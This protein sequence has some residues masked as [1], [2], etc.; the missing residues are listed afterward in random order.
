MKIIVNLLS[1]KSII[2]LSTTFSEKFDMLKREYPYTPDFDILRIIKDEMNFLYNLKIDGL[3]NLSTFT[4][5]DERKYTVVIRP[6]SIEYVEIY[7]E[8]E[9]RSDF[10]DYAESIGFSK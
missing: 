8:P 1:G 4:M 10:F 7:D 2:G 6:D 3:M 9:F 5:I